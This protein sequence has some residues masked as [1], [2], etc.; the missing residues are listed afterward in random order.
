MSFDWVSERKAAT[1]AFY[2]RALWLTVVVH[3]AMA[4]IEGVGSVVTGSIGLMAD[5]DVHQKRNPD[6]DEEQPPCRRVQVVG[7]I[8]YGGEIRGRSSGRSNRALY[9]RIGHLLAA[10]SFP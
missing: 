7:Q 8:A 5:A 2:R 10:L 9:D 4:V 1:D 3:A 6:P